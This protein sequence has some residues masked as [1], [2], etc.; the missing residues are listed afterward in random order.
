MNDFGL[1]PYESW[2]HVPILVKINL[3]LCKQVFGQQA[4]LKQSVA[5]LLKK[6]RDKCAVLEKF[7]GEV[8]G[9][10]RRRGK[11]T[12]RKYEQEYESLMGSRYSP[13]C[14]SGF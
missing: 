8:H 9:K 2:E 4:S 6:L 14:A 12:G 1:I 3:S 10:L 5:G 13:Y 11:A 7:C